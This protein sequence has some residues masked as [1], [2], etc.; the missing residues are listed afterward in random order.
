MKCQNKTC[1]NHKSS[2]NEQWNDTNGKEQWNSD[3]NFDKIKNGQ[4][5]NQMEM[6]NHL[7]DNTKRYHQ[8]NTLQQVYP[9]QFKLVWN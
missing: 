1:P 7:K 5:T 2:G 9:R 4:T 6:K 8:L 3:K